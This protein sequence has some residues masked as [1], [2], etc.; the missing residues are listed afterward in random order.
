MSAPRL[1]SVLIL[2]VPGF[3]GPVLAQGGPPLLTDDPFTPRAWHW[4]INSALSVEHASGMSATEMPAL[5]LNYGWGP[6]LQLKVEGPYRWVASEDGHHHGAGNALAGAKYRFADAWNGWAL[7]TYPQVEVPMSGRRAALVGGDSA[8]AFFLPVEAAHSRGNLEFDTEV[9]YWFG[10]PELRE[11]TYGVVLG[12]T[13]T[14]KLELLS[15]CNAHGIRPFHPAELVCGL[16]A[17]Q[18]LTEHVGLMGAFEP[19]VAGAEPDKPTYHMY[20][21]IQTHIRGGGFW[22]GARRAL[23][24]K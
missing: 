1:V 20:L 8:W 19:V 13:A 9:G 21:G 2:L 14:R 16:G 6:R 17:R 11:A 18:D 24:G 4:E 5:D 23:I 15:E 3:A 22:R 7:S 12:W 10:P